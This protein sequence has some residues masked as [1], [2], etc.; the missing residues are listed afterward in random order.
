MNWIRI[1]IGIKGD[2][3]IRRMSDALKVQPAEIIGCIVGL[4]AEF[5]A[6][7]PDGDLSAVSSNTLEDWAGWRRKR[8]VFAAV[9]REE[10]CTPDGAVRSWEKYNG[11]AIAKAEREVERVRKWREEQAALRE[12]ERDSKRVQS[13][14]ET[15]TVRVTE[16]VA[17]E[18][19]T[20]Q[21][22]VTRRDELLL[23]AT[24]VNSLAPPDKPASALIGDIAPKRTKPEPK[25][26]HFPMPLCVEMH[27]MWCEGRGGNVLLPR[28]RQLFGPIFVR[29]ES[30]RPP[31]APTNDELK[32]ALK[33]VLDL[34]PGGSGAPYLTAAN[35]AERLSA[36]AKVRREYAADDFG[37]VA[38][39]ER[40]LHGRAA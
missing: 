24:A 23:K 1:A 11:K 12:A 5:P 38:A 8:G 35:V 15:R 40:I 14:D 31:E 29:A 18:V 13:P 34:G 7:A 3:A 37:R 2:P 22:N 6:H 19:R 39:V 28:F 20:V 10:L 21:R 4:L 26:P 16:R 27:A 32:L 25:F 33:S 36:I 9:F 30:D 17:N